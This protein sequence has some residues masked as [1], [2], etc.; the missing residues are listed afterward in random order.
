MADLAYSKLHRKPDLADAQGGE[1]L[2][3]ASIKLRLDAR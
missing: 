1:L 3:N 2:E